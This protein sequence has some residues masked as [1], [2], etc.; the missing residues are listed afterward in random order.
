VR[1]NQENGTALLSLA[2][3]EQVILEQMPH[4]TTEVGLVALQIVE[5]GAYI[6]LKADRQ[7]PTRI[8]SVDA[9]V[10]S[11]V[12]QRDSASEIRE[13]PEAELYRYVRPITVQLLHTPH[14]NVLQTS[15]SYYIHV[16]SKSR[17]HRILKVLSNRNRAYCD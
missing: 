13:L 6:W 15:R 8:P 14:D 16:Q 9:G 17:T 4:M 10:R 7:L 5:P 2:T 11:G 1:S 3:E 12:Q